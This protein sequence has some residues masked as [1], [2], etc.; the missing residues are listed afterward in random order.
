MPIKYRTLLIDFLNILSWYE[1]QR[2]ESYTY[3]SICDDHIFSYLGIL[4]DNTV[5][6]REKKSHAHVPT[7]RQKN[8]I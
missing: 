4:I 1:V 7:I 2:T 8:P 3:I 6:G 5:P